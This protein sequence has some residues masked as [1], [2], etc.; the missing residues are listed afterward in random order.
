MNRTSIVIAS[1][2]RRLRAGRAVLARSVPR[3]A[4]HGVA[5]ARPGGAAVSGAASSCT[6]TTARSL[7]AL[8]RAV[9]ALWRS[10]CFGAVRQPVPFGPGSANPSIERTYNGGWP[11]AAPAAVCAPLYAAHVERYAASQA[12]MRCS[13]FCLC[14][15]QRCA[16]ARRCLA[17]AR[18]YGLSRVRGAV[19]F[20]RQRRAGSQAAAQRPHPLRSF[21]AHAPAVK[22]QRCR[23]PCFASRRDARH[24]RAGATGGPL[25]VAARHNPSIERTYN[26]GRPC[27]VLR[28][29]RAPLYAAHVER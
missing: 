4:V 21:L 3:A 10:R 29:S 19:F 13:S 15:R 1:S 26:G 11:C 14:W 27:A 16:V 23:R 8:H 2:L 6:G 24:H 22:H 20:L 28:A 9:P 17:L 18:T 12:R 25:R 7:H 5:C